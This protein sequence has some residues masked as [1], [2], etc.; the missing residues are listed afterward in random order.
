MT[1]ADN[2]PLAWFLRTYI[3]SVGGGNQVNWSKSNTKHWKKNYWRKKL[4]VLNIYY[5]SKTDVVKGC[6]AFSA[7]RPVCV[8]VRFFQGSGLCLFQFLQSSLSCS[9][10]VSCNISETRRLIVQL[11]ERKEMSARTSNWQQLNKKKCCLQ[12]IKTKQ[13]IELKQSVKIN[14]GLIFSCSNSELFCEIILGACFMEYRFWAAVELEWAPLSMLCNILFFLFPSSSARDVCSVTPSLTS[15]EE[16]SVLFYRD[17]KSQLPVT[18]TQ[19]DEGHTRA[20]RNWSIWG[21]RS[22]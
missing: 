5:V 3:M 11:N 17:N 6:K 2:N 10:D 15:S 20:H 9:A 21:F 16:R 1:R 13:N 14:W 19:T 18:L 8:C 7:R 12:E 22:V 4:Y